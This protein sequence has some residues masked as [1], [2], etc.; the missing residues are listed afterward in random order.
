MQAHASVTR[1]AVTG[2]ITLIVLFVLCWLGA[3]L[4]PGAFTHLFVALFTSAPMTS[5]LALVEGVCSALLFG[6]LAGGVLALTYN[7]TAWSERKAS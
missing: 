1:F 5:W 7:F 4:W 6:F 3:V 2:A